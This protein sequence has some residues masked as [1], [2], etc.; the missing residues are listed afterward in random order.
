MN[1]RSNPLPV[2]A[3]P[4]EARQ[5]RPA[6]KTPATAK[7]LKASSAKKPIT[8]KRKGPGEGS[9]GQHPFTTEGQ[10]EK[11]RK[12]TTLTESIRNSSPENEV[13]TSILTADTSSTYMDMEALEL[14]EQRQRNTSVSRYGQLITMSPAAK[15][16]SVGI[17]GGAPSS[18]GSLSSVH[19]SS[20]AP[21]HVGSPRISFSQASSPLRFE[22]ESSPLRFERG[23]DSEPHTPSNQLRVES[24]NSMSKPRYGSRSMLGPGDLGVTAV[25]ET[26]SR[27]LEKYLLSKN[28]FPTESELLMVMYSDPRFVPLA[29][30]ANIGD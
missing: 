25:L 5:N 20:P 6:K 18:V 10:H 8:K 7:N 29:N 2:L 17:R 14:E 16:V 23:D 19:Q 3:P 22:L 12:Q 1:T 30:V 24:A 27:M 28:P 11:K 4:T 26:A 15:I 9:K 13:N 21:Q